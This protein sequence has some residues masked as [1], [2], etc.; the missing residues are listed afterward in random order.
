MITIATWQLV[1]IIV[2]TVIVT[3]AV[4]TESFKKMMKRFDKMRFSSDKR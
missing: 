1:G 4:V 3:L 2:V